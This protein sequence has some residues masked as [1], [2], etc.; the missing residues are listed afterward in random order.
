MSC[1]RSQCG[2]GER[3]AVVWYASPHLVGKRGSKEA[4]EGRVVGHG[5]V[6]RLQRG[7]EAGGHLVRRGRRARGRRPCVP[8]RRAIG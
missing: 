7:V 3:P 1:C 5:V 8:P 4:D 2:G 6:Q